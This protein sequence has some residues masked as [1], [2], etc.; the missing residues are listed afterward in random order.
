MI[1][2]NAGAKLVCVSP[3]EALRRAVLGGLYRLHFYG[4]VGVSAEPVSDREFVLQEPVGHLGGS[5]A[6]REARGKDD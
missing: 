4:C 1:G 2:L 6:R 3:V 5:Y